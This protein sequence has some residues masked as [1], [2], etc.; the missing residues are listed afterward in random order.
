LKKI[1][2]PLDTTKKKSKAGIALQGTI[3]FLCRRRGPPTVLS[4][5]RTMRE[6]R[7]TGGKGRDGSNDESE[8][9]KGLRGGVG[10]GKK[11]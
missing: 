5:L 9:K 1:F 10:K 2:T 6:F 7:Q 3:H 11:V 4:Q 8:L